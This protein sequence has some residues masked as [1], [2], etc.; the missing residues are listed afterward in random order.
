MREP[1]IDLGLLEPVPEAARA[2]GRVGSPR[3]RRALPVWSTA[4]LV[5]A[6]AAGSASPPVLPVSVPA[7]ID[8]RFAVVGDLLFVAVGQHRAHGHPGPAHGSSSF[9]W[10]AHD[11]S[12]GE[13]LWTLSGLGERLDLVAAGGLLW[14]GGFPLD[15]AT[16]RWLSPKRSGVPGGYRYLGVPGGQTVVTSGGYRPYSDAAVDLE[17]TYEVMGVDTITG[18]VQWR[19]EPDPGVRVW[20]AGAP[21]R[22]IMISSDE[23]V[24]VRDPDTGAVLASRRV[25]DAISAELAGDRLLVWAWSPGGEVLHAFA[26]DTMVPLWELPEPAGTLGPCGAMLCAHVV[27]E[28]TRTATDTM[29]GDRWRVPH[30]TEVI[31]PATGALAWTTGYRLYPIGGRF[32]G[33]DDRGGLRAL[34]DAR[35]GRVLRDLAGWQAVVPPIGD[36]D[37]LRRVPLLRPGPAGEVQVARLDPATGGLTDL[38]QLPGH[39]LRCQPYP[40]GVVCLHADRVWVWPLGPGDG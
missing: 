30:R 5:L 35:D 8:G 18:V 3:R 12:T 39:P 27:A 1:V 21:A 15:P 20:L 40:D 38:G 14:D 4:L 36:G 29:T 34:L 28:Q 33:Y 31:D 2:G 37:D 16:G 10:A 22:L 17:F 13:R 9:D 19:A 25:P 11:M 7:P 23:L 6:L 26:R 24:S 32:L